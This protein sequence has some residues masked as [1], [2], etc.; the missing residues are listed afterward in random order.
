MRL[1]RHLFLSAALLAQY[2]FAGEAEWK[3]YM[4]SGTAAT[5]RGD[6]RDATTRYEA[7]LK[8]AA[9]FGFEDI[10]YLTTE[11]YIARSYRA[12]GQF[13]VAEQ[14]FKRLLA[15]GERLFGLEHPH[16]GTVLN[17]LATLYTRQGRYPEAESLFK[18]AMAIREGG[19]KPNDLDLAESFYEMAEVYKGSGRYKEAEYSL[20]QA[21]TIAGKTLGPEN[22]KYALGMNSLAWVY[23]LQKRYAEAEQ[24]I[25]RVLVIWEKAY[26]PDS[27]SLASA[28]GVL[29][30]L[31]I[32]GGR[33]SEAEAHL[34]R[35]LEIYERSY[36]TEHP[37][38]VVALTNLAIVYERQG[39]I[40]K[41][42]DSARRATQILARR[43]A[44]DEGAS[45][46][47]A[48]VEQRT[49]AS[50]FE[51]HIKMLFAADSAKRKAGKVADV[52]DSLE[53]FEI[54]QLS[55]ASDTAGQVALMA[56]RYAAGSDALAEVTRRRQDLA[57]KWEGIDSALL[58]DVSKP[59]QQRDA[60][61]E[62][63][64]RSDQ[65][66]VAV[67]I[68]GL[69]SRIAEAYP[70]YAA[71][72]NPK[73]LGVQSVQELLL[74]DEALVLYVTSGD[75][76]FV[77]VIRQAQFQ[78]LWM[79]VTRT[80]LDDAVRKLRAQLDFTAIEPEQIL[81]R[82]FDVETAHALYRAILAPA[83]SLLE[84]VK[85]LIVIPDGALQSLPLGVLVTET[86]SLPRTL[87][88]HADV[89]WLAKKYAITTL[90]AV[91]SL[92]ALRA[93]AKGP[94]SPDPFLGFGDPLLDG[95]GAKRGAVITG[96]YSRGAVA[97]TRDVRM[98]ARLPETAKELRA[99][100][101]SLKAPQDRVRLGT[102]AT[103]QAVKQTDL[104][105]YRTLAFATHGLMAGDFKGLAEPALVLT[106]P[107]TGSEL[108]DGLLTAGE[109]SQLKLNADWVILSACNTAA[110][111]GTPGAEGLSGL[112]RAFF[113]AGARSLLVSHWSVSSDAAVALTT[114]MFDE[115]AKGVTKAE[116]LRR[117][118][119]SLMETP[120]KPHYAHPAFWAP[121]VVV[122]EGG[123][124]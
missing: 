48:L 33:Y 55:R 72:T 56:A 85:H 23:V 124:R 30:W 113:Y 95:G 69:D 102:A 12:R 117:S 105:R 18:R 22:P 37:D 54:A 87:A 6:Y 3:A 108:D 32:T 76:T 36:G 81:S 83:E 70:Q 39:A 88:D 52:R 25:Q 65:N 82:P 43:F 15:T 14:T 98:L 94:P 62:A 38:V 115:S 42:L 110:P 101:A 34:K 99:I 45:R 84:G 104:S 86:G 27:L 7:A 11:F 112:A 58:R 20:K 123:A 68:A 46:A 59:A 93:F 61:R 26:G 49:K 21:L 114:R 17:A 79:P 75:A 80:M 50:A 53:S 28:L 4:E 100:A 44:I 57:A 97:D 109:I 74:P 116:A 1:A 64:L 96:L 10:R 71:L 67:Q 41:S 8:E 29:G 121:F 92:R 31:D 106:P 16:I 73:P 2:V 89:A 47:G 78:Y 66:D 120:G 77:W 5:D 122:G 19:M 63:R 107:E 119:L 118:M 40:T 111:D 13:A 35:I 51:L 9:Q 90:P 103:E 60:Q 91:S 24:L